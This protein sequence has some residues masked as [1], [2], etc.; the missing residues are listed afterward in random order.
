MKKLLSELQYFWKQKCYVLV[1][2]M[3]AICGYGFEITHYSIGI[4]DTAIELYLEDGLAP[5]MGRWTMFLV[6][7]IFHMS[8]FSP[9]MLEFIGVLLLCL[10]AT[11]FCVLFRRIFEDRIGIWGYIVFSCVFVSNPIIS[12]VYIYYFHN[13]VDLAY[14]LT[15]LSWL[16]FWDGMQCGKGKRKKALGYY[17][18][19][20]ALITAASGCCESLLVMFVLGVLLLLFLQGVSGNQRMKSRYIFAQLGIGAAVTVGS[21]VLRTLILK[22]I[23]PLFSLQDMIGLMNQRNITEIFKLFQADQPLQEVWMLLKRFWVVYYV[24]AVV[25]LPVTCYMIAALIFLL[26]AINLGIRRKDAW[27]LI[28]FV[29]MMLTPFLLTIMEG[30]VTLYRTCQYLPFFCA[31]GFLLA[32]LFVSER[33]K[34]L[35]LRTAY[36]VCTGTLVYNQAA[37]LNQSFYADYKRYENTKEILMQVAYEIERTYGDDTPVVFTGHYNT[38]YCLSKDYYVSYGSWQY[39]VIATITDKV[40]PHLKE[41][42]FTPYGY[43]FVGE[44]NYPF[45]L[46]AIGAFNGTN[47]QMMNFLEMHGHS[48]P[49]IMDPEILA[50][51]REIGDT[52][53]GWPAEGSIT[54]QDGYILVHFE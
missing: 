2:T 53:P 40:D 6:N 33:K 34:A 28:L 50:Q 23:I 20:V 49:Q 16:C 9:F 38:P 25:Y 17:L 42:Y 13:G 11:L 35:W 39:R 3:T 15:A 46:W 27:Y 21:V 1:L 54:E 19:A 26:F 48:F 45:I 31:V 22:M 10:A 12:E 36:L 44:A 51:A 14:I 29:G 41:K 47:W 18:G 32:Y 52:M 30:N 8:N 24:N 7:K 37:A 43:S 5:V 4:D